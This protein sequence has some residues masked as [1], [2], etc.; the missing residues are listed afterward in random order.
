MKTNTAYE[1]WNDRWETSEG[2]A[3][4]IEPEPF[5]IK[6]LEMIRAF[7]VRTV[8]DM[9]CGPGRHAIL[10]AQKEFTVHALDASQYAVDLLRRKSNELDLNIQVNLGEM[11]D[12]NFENETFDMV[13]AWN[14]IYHGDMSV[15]QH[16]LS[17]ISRILR[18]K[19][20]F[21]GTML[22]MRNSEIATGQEI[23]HRTF[24][25][26]NVLDKSHPHFYCNAI[27]LL[28]LFAGFEP[29]VLDDREHKR[30]GSYHWHCI[31]EKK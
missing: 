29:L 13:V 7:K 25:N 4:Y 9:G 30:P 27:E 23:A 5:V 18:R 17:E 15:V 19:G 8:L 2:C 22:S 24:V 10:L 31:M 1:H 11:T 6:A 28:S 26:E 3:D 14:V 12:L 21:L 16:S 20:L